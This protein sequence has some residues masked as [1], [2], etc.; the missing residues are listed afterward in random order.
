MP[1]SW[2][3]TLKTE[4]WTTEEDNEDNEE[5]EDTQYHLIDMFTISKEASQKA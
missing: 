5:E 3:R 1:A 2:K 4:G